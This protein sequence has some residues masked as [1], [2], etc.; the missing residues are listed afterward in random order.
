MRCLFKAQYKLE[1]LTG[2]PHDDDWCKRWKK[3]EKKT[4]V[5][6]QPQE[7]HVTIS[8][9]PSPVTTSPV[10]EYSIYE[11]RDKDEGGLVFAPEED[12]VT[13]QMV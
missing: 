7:Q 8:V 10:I 11:E 12:K 13:N 6:P 1:K 4:V 9:S 5:Q 2:A 3:K